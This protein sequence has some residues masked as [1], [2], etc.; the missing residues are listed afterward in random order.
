[1]NLKLIHFYP[2][3][4]GLYG[5]YANV[6]VL[7]RTLEQMGNSVTVE[8]VEQ[9][10]DADIAHADFIYMGAGT[11]RRQ[12]FALEDFQRF[13]SQIRAAAESGTAMLFA[14]TAMEMLGKSVAD[15]RNSPMDGIGLGDFTVKQG[16]KRIVGDVYGHTALY[17]APIVGF[18]NKAS[19][20]KG[21]QTPLIQR[22]DLGFGNE[23]DHGAE[24]FLY[25]NVIGSCLTGPILVKNP[26]LL[27]HVIAA[28]YEKRGEALPPF[29]HDPYAE[30][31]YAVTER[32]L[33]RRC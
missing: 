17:D 29:P 26:R 12:K 27:Q 15:W 1:M 9:G 3:L 14:G 33:K 21:V 5:S 18:M 31:A 19:V 10:E 16:K 13:G 23:A 7:R 32:E 25:R 11:E 8:R 22:L 2:D 20:I 6:A 28:I 30:N 4:M 24:G